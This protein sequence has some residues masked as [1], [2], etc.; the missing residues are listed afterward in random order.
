MLQINTAIEN[1]TLYDG[2]K[3]KPSSNAT[4]LISGEKIA[5]AGAHSKTPS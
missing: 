1:V 2:A 5:Y 4:V 3:D